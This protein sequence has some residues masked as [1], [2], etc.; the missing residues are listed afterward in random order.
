MIA[1]LSVIGLKNFATSVRF[2]SRVS[3]ELYFE[4]KPE[5]LILRVLGSG[6]SWYDFCL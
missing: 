2:L 3:D 1:K 6:K 4:A 5:C